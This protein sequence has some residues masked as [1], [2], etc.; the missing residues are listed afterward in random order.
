MRTPI[1]RWATRTVLASLGLIALGGAVSPAESQQVMTTVANSRIESILDDMQVSYTKKSDT[2]W[3]L[4]LED[5]KAL[6]LMGTDNEDAQLYIGFGDVKVTSSQ[7]NEWNKNHR[8]GRAYMD[9][10]GNPAL[11]ADLDFAGGVTEGAIQAWINLFR[12]QIK[13]YVKYLNGL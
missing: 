5:Y 6:L 9:D 1:V 8:F 12:A 13:A 2:S 11:E 4:Q 3:R 7:M 10:D